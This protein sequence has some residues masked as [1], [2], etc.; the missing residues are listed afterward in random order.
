[1]G[2]VLGGVLKGP[3]LES[4]AR[5][6]LIILSLIWQHLD[7]V[8]KGRL[9]RRAQRIAAALWKRLQYKTPIASKEHVSVCFS[10]RCAKTPRLS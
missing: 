5:N 2:Q 9:Q 8:A 4:F 1:M 6:T 3:P 7:V 10:G